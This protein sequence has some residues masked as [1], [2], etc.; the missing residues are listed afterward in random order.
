MSQIQIPT[1]WTTKLLEDICEDIQPGFAQGKKDVKNG[2]VHLR[3]NNIGTNFEINFDLV[4]TID[5]I[6]EQLKKY[7]LEKDDILFNNT[8]SSKLVG[9]SAIFNNPKTCL[10]SNHL[11]RIRV[12][13]QLS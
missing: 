9:K 1:R 10:Y 8:N 6:P 7:K 13:N 11:T 5:V 3:M 12:K 2:V 4:R